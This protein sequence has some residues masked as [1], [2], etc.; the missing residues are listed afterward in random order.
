M[1][2]IVAIDFEST[3]SSPGYQNT[4]WQIGLVLLRDG[5]LCPERQ[6][7]SL[8]RVPEE[9]P[10][11]LYTPGRWASLRKELAQAPTLPELW[12]TLQ[13]WFTG[14]ALLAHNVPVERSL[15]RAFF[16]FHQFAPWLDSL[17][18]ARLAFPGQISYKLADLCANLGLSGSLTEL[19]PDSSP[20]DAL[21]DAMACGCLL[22]L[23]LQE[24]SWREAG[25]EQ[26]ASLKAR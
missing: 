24:P 3:G 17:V 21:Y 11:N 6:F 13:S 4:P 25:I 7:S 10:F 1:R 19:C 2:E 20:H 15:L 8:L 23:I 5:R 26:L 18:L 14:R 12:P 9:Q 22:Q 16:P